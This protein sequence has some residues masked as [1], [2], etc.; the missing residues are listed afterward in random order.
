MSCMLIYGFVKTVVHV[1]ISIL[2]VLSFVFSCIQALIEEKFRQYIQA[3]NEIVELESAVEEVS[4]NLQRI[5]E[6]FSF[7][8]VSNG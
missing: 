5:E 2:C 1:C 6:V 8:G 3:I 7:F 4:S